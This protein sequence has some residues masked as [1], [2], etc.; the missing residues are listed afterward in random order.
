MFAN[1]TED[2]GLPM[3]CSQMTG[4]VWTED[5][6]EGLFDGNCT[7]Y[8]PQCEPERLDDDYY[9]LC[10]KIPSASSLNFFDRDLKYMWMTRRD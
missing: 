7:I 10:N 3:L 8:G 9:H 1:N 6:V 4:N 2:G 5:G